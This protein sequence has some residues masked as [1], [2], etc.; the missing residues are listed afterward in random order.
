VGGHGRHGLGGVERGGLGIITA[1]TLPSPDAL[2]A[3]IDRCRALTDQPFGV[4]LTL[5]P[6]LNPPP[7]ADYRRAIIESGVK[8]VETAGHNPREHV[9]DFKSHG[10]TVLH[11]CT[12][13][14]HALS[15]ERMGP[16]SSASTALNAPATPARTTFP[17]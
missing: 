1:L 12:A 17:A 14:R 15:A 10:I 7:Y 8:I 6:S 11:K 4:N 13:V 2:R 5:L 16:T 9:E 3:E